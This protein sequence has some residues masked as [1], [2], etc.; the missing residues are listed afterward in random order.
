MSLTTEASAKTCRIGLIS[1]PVY[2]PKPYN[3]KDTYLVLGE[4]F[5]KD[6]QNNLEILT[7]LKKN[8][9]YLYPF[10]VKKDKDKVNV[11]NKEDFILF[12]KKYKLTTTVTL[13]NYKD[14]DNNTE[15]I[16]FRT[17]CL[18]D[19]SCMEP[20]FPETCFLPKDVKI[21]SH[22][23]IFLVLPYYDP[24]LRGEILKQC[25]NTAKN[26]YCL[27]L[28]TGNRYGKNKETTSTLMKRYLLSTGVRSENIN[29]SKYDKF[30]D[31]IL[32]SLKIL[33]F[34]LNI[35][36]YVTCDLFIACSSYDIHEVMT[37][38]R[39]SRIGKDIKIQFLCD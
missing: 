21:S 19:I 27:Y 23:R 25:V 3:N 9:Q 2:S 4:I 34:I 17:P 15:K 30:P 20:L 28:L 11:Y 6:I 5:D 26:H 38:S 16:V 7:E 24:I 8:L 14:S 10:K 33:P 31:S 32:E 39:D 29:K 22:C 13:L 1:W 18:Y 12:R 36:H 35:D 37:F